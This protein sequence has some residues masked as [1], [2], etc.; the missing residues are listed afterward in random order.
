MQD[1]KSFANK[2]DSIST[3]KAVESKNNPQI[4]LLSD[5]TDSRGIRHVT[6]QTTATGNDRE[7]YKAAEQAVKKVTNTQA[8]GRS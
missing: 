2:T 1:P 5:T 8:E 7:G 4:R 3:Q 6:I